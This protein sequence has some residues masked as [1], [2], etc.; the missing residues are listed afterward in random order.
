MLRHLLRNPISSLLFSW[1]VPPLIFILVLQFFKKKYGRG[2]RRLK[3]HKSKAKVYV[4]DDESK[5]A[6]DD[7]AGV[8]EA[9]DELTEIVD[10]LKRPENIQYWARIPK[11]VL[12]LDLE[13]G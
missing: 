12:L 5:T 8:D 6:F 2:T 1:V 13:D 3:L 4:P 11:G 7:V 9:K 10:F